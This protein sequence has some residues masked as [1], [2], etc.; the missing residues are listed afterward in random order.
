[1]GER[2]GAGWKEDKKKK[3]RRLTHPVY[4]Y[5]CVVRVSECVGV[6]KEDFASGRDE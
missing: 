6:D 2:G 1:M 4:V 5:D 3:R